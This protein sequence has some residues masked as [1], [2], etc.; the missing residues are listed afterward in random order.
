MIQKKLIGINSL[1]LI[2]GK[3]GGTE[4]F[5]V[6]QVRELSKIKGGHKYI[7]YTNI[8]NYKLFRSFSKDFTIINTHIHAT[9]RIVRILWEQF[10]LPFW[11]YRDKVDVLH[12]P[13]YTSPIFTHCKKITTIFDL[14][15]HFHPEDFNFLE[16]LVY[17]V[18]IPLSA[19]AS[20]KI[21]VHSNKSKED[22]SDVLHVT[23]QKIEV[24]YAGV[25]NEF[26]ANIDYKKSLN[27][28]KKLGIAPP[29]ILANST[30]HPHKNLQSLV[31]AF[32]QMA[33]NKKFKHNL[34]L[35]GIPGK[36]YT[37]INKLIMAEGLGKRVQFTNKWIKNTDLRYFY[38]LADVF[39]QPSLYEGFG[40]PL[41]E[42]LAVGTPV[43]ASK[44]SCIPE[45]VG[46]TQ[47]TLDTKRPEILASSILSLL[48]NKKLQTKMSRSG[49]LRA[50]V[51]SWPVFGQKIYNLYAHV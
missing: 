25:A 35:I 18:L 33:K 7:I 8:E 12:S 23:K 6:N 14:N 16:R 5:L 21:I 48:R 36:A 41:I 40:L 22:M 10:I 42:A 2:P 44:Y 39:V 51:F 50:K 37:A 32:I 1:F 19:Y 45:I 29:Y 30:S 20:D 49:K 34:V 47:I 24:I 26:N 27:F 31:L 13:G 17:S 3:V 38:K 9:N 46:P 15:Y 11:L 43:V 4:V 28:V